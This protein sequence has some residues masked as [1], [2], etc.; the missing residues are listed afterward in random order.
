VNTNVDFTVNNSTVKCVMRKTADVIY[1]DP[2]NW[3][4][5]TDNQLFLRPQRLLIGNQ[6]VNLL[7]PE[8]YI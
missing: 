2:G 7:A 8:F 5:Y 6:D 3:L 4:R 1:R